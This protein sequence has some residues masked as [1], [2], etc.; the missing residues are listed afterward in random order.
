MNQN[1]LIVDDEIEILSWLEEL[2]RFESGLSLDV[3]TAN[4]AMEAMK[5]LSRVRFDAVLTDIRM[6]GMDGIALFRQIKDNWPRCKTIFLTGY[7]SFEDMYEL[8]QHKDVQYILKSEP[9]EVIVQ[10]VTKALDQ[11]RRELEQERT[12]AEYKAWFGKT[13]HWLCRELLDQICGGTV[14]Q[15]T[16]RRL[17]E[18]EIPV[19]PERESL[20]FLLR[21]DRDGVNI[22]ESRYMEEI[23]IG[24]LHQNVPTKLRFYLHLLGGRMAL[25]IIQ[26]ADFTNPDWENVK[27]VAL[28]ALEFAQEQVKAACGVTFSAVI[29]GKTYALVEFQ[30]G[31]AD[32][33]KYMI[34]YIGGAKE[35]ILNMDVQESLQS[36][37]DSAPA[38]QTVAMKN[39]LET[40]K[41]REYFDLLSGCLSW[42]VKREKLQDPK[43]L[44]VY[45]TLSIFLLQFIN[46]N[47]M[48]DQIAQAVGIH[49]LTIAGIHAS[50]A[51]AARYLLNVSEA[52]FRELEATEDTLSDRAL[53]RVVTYIEEHLDDELSLTTLANV[54]G[55][56]A[57]YLSRLFRQVTGETLTAYIL[58][59]RMTLAKTLLTGTNLKIQDIALR[60]GYPSA[61]S[62]TRAFRTEIGISPTDYRDTAKKT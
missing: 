14:P 54:G 20:L 1:L 37:S 10:A 12:A 58:R 43:A 7:G 13:R 9:D 19:D 26:P 41:K 11:S 44:E 61:H 5:L 40:H 62:F 25:L 45:Y 31:L 18:L 57:S 24:A 4:S 42:L 48:N 22:I 36:T 38:V 52:I 27:A 23:V 32:L 59:R 6:P 50:W 30:Q 60:I 39:L 2:F 35:A 33:R 15:D 3:Y 21:L 29:S 51:E 55:F 56:N 46:E 8:I 49:Q 16:A 34:S 53:K 17:Q 28:G 47:R